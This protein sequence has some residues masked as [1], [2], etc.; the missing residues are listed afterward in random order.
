[1]RKLRVYSKKIKKSNKTSTFSLDILGS[2]DCMITFKYVF[3]RTKSILLVN[4]FI[5][6]HIHYLVVSNAEKFTGD[7]SSDN[8]LSLSLVKDSILFNNFLLKNIH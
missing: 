1:M 8:K 5:W 7:L 2:R 6:F 3:D 4:T